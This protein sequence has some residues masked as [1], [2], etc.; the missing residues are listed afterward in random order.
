MDVLVTGLNGT[1]AP[2]LARTLEAR[3]HRIIR[4]DRTLV[5]PD[6][7]DRV[8][9]FI[10]AESPHAIAHLATGPP[11]WAELLARVAQETNIRLLYTSSV[12]VYGDDQS[13]PFAPDAIPTP[14]SEYGKYKL[15]CEHRIML[16]NP[17]SIVVRIGWQI[18]WERGGNHMV[19][20]L[21]KMHDEQGEI[22][23]STNWYQ[24][25]SFLEDTSD[26]LTTLLEADTFGLY[27][28]DSNPG[29]S[30]YEIVSKLNHL[31]QA[32]WNVQ[33]DTQ[34]SINNRLL[35]DRVPV[36]SLRDVFRNV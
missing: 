4:W 23:A 30:F 33:P 29:L 36:R 31:I 28:L 32:S 11:E 27:H 13:G 6:N 9:S 5:P 25:C 14:G 16:V 34:P 18:G 7:E 17:R 15:D 20:H 26:S 24:A 12:S 19:D 3:G 1:V 8:R 22:K 2:V 21:H 10:D 35:D